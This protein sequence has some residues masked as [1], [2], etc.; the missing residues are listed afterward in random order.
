MQQAEE[1]K[2]AQLRLSRHKLS[3]RLGGEVV[4]I[5]A[6]EGEAAPPNSPVM[7]IINWQRVHIE[8]YIDG[9]AYDGGLRNAPVKFVTDSPTGG[10]GVEFSGRV[11]WVSAE[12]EPVSRQTL[13]RAEVEN[14]RKNGVWLLRAGMQ[15]KLTVDLSGPR[16]PAV[17][18]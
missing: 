2:S 18:K 12:L 7:R 17:K 10:K 5:F 14:V 13:L 6:H 15:G 11:L 3:A 16:D 9:A 8:A 1:L 4:E